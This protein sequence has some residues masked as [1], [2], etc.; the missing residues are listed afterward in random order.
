M[1]SRGYGAERP[2]HALTISKSN[3]TRA[4]VTNVLSEDH[5]GSALIL[6]YTLQKN[7]P[8][9]TKNADLIVQLSRNCK[10]KQQ[11]LVRL[12]QIG[13]EIHYDDETRINDANL[14]GQHRNGFM[15]L[16]LWRW[17][18]YKKVVWLDAD[19]MVLGDISL[20]LSENYRMTLRQAH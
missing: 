13:W 1:A 11:S 5:V 3:K 9:I 18:Q 14:A 6:G 12:A 10:I 19:C 20:L 15:K 2:I 17:T 7:N 4:V 8:T 16:Q